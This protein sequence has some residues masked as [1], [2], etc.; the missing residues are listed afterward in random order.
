MSDPAFIN[1]DFTRQL[2]STDA[3]LQLYNVNESMLYFT[4]PK[5]DSKST[6][7]RLCNNLAVVEYG[8]EENGRLNLG[9]Y[10]LHG[11]DKIFIRFSKDDLKIDTTRIIKIE[12]G[13]Y[14]YT[15]SLNELADFSGNMVIYGGKL[16]LLPDETNDAANHGAL[17]AEKNEPSLVRLVT[18]IIGNE[19]GT[20]KIAQLL[21]NF[22][23]GAVKF[24][25]KEAYGKYEILKRPNEVLM[26]GKSDCSGMTILYASLLEQAGVDY[27]LVY[28]PGHINTAVEG[29]FP[30]QNSLNFE[31]NGK[32]YFIAET[33]AKEFNIGESYLADTIGIKDI[34]YIQKPGKNSELVKYEK[35][36]KLQ[37]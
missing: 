1:A 2:T 6:I 32:T 30:K 15:Q 11:T 4:I 18:Q 23:S 21:L 17:V 3:E 36:S 13:K 33:T 12:Y 8:K 19:T 35:N 31:L 26:S 28:Y 29:N 14:L 5:D 7:S 22:V 10:S 9:K 24:N 37:H 20:E 16:D 34:L 27:R 25:E